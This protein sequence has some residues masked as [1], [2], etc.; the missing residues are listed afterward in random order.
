MHLFWL[1]TFHKIGR[2]AAASQELLQLLMLDSGQDSWI[3]DL[4]A[5][6]MQDW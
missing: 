2:P 6:Q 4:I 3:T 1:I 5:I